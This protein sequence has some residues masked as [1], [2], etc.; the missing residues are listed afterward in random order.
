MLNSPGMHSR[1]KDEIVGTQVD[2]SGIRGAGCG[3]L[4]ESEAVECLGVRV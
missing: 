1:S 2:Q 4:Y 3:A